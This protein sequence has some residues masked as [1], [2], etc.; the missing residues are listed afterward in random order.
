MAYVICL[1][2]LFGLSACNVSVRNPSAIDDAPFFKVL[3]SNVSGKQVLLTYYGA[4]ASSGFGTIYESGEEVLFTFGEDG[5]LSSTDQLVLIDD[6]FEI[7]DREFI[8]VDEANELEYALSVNPL[9]V[10][11]L[12]VSSIDG[13]FY[14][15]FDVVLEGVEANN[16]SNGNTIT[17]QET[18]GSLLPATATGQYNTIFTDV[19]EGSPFGEGDE[20]LFAFFSAGPLQLGQQ[21]FEVDDQFDVRGSEFVWE[22]KVNN[23]EYAMTLTEDEQV[24]EIAVYDLQTGEYFGKFEVL[25]R[26][27]Q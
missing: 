20:L 17:E 24:G 9:G 16:V 19:Q 8:W 13:D 6:N 23:L 14:G 2:V 25:E 3:P 22:S 18:G 21:M 27:P 26:V 11:S 7:R 5:S 15:Q 10:G 1:L 4:D 12:K